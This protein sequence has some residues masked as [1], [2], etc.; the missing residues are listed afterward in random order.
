[1][2]N[3][4]KKKQHHLSFKIDDDREVGP[5]DVAPKETVL[6]AALRT[7]TNF[8]H[9]CKVGGCGACKCKLISGRVKELTDSSYLLS[10]EEIAGSYI[11][12]C[13]SVPI[14]DVIVQVPE[15]SQEQVVHGTL[16]SQ[17]ILTHDTVEISIKLDSSISYQSGQYAVLKIKE[18]DIPGRCYSFAR[19]SKANNNEVVFVIKSVPDG[20]LSNFLQSREATNCKLELTGGIGNFYLRSGSENLLLIAGGSGLAPIIS[21]LESSLDLGESKRNVQLFVGARSQGDIFYQ[22]EINAL[23]DQWKGSFDYFPVLSNEPADSDWTGKRGFMFDAIGPID[24]VS[25]QAYLCG[26]PIMIDTCVAALHDNGLEDTSIF[27][28]KFAD[29]SKSESPLATSYA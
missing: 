10:R 2:F 27:S 22:E 16:I 6:N 26:P 1:M 29:Q 13:Q 3:I 21:L 12:G 23:A 28:D 9:S 4:F 17:K 11:L 19:S 7:G 18:S 15:M 25:T 14:T 8:P 20:K 5:F 24:S